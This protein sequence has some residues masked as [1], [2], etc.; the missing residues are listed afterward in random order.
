M[1]PDESPLK[2]TEGSKVPKTRRLD[3]PP[4]VKERMDQYSRDL[5]KALVDNLNRPRDE[6]P[7]K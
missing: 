4:E 5:G 3:H 6:P 7:A 1:K 2:P